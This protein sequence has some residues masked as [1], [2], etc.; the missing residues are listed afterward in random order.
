MYTLAYV[1]SSTGGFRHYPSNKEPLVNGA[2]KKYDPRLR[3]WYVAAITGQKNMVIMIDISGYMSSVIKTV[4]TTA[5]DLINSLSNANFVSVIV[6]NN[7]AYSLVGGKI[8]K[9]TKE[10]KKNLI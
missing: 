6:F 4:K 10:Y 5:I 8:E 2:C 9:A 7:S 1:G 3:P